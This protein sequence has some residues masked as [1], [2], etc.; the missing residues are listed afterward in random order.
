MGIKISKNKVW[1]GIFLLF[2]GFVLSEAISMP[3]RVDADTAIRGGFFPGILSVMIILLSIILLF[4]KNEP[5]SKE[6][7]NR[8]SLI[9][10]LLIV[11]GIAAYIFLLTKLG[12]LIAGF[13]FV[14]LCARTLG[15]QSWAK[16]ILYSALMVLTIHIVFVVLLNVRFPIG[17]FGI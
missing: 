1:A 7:I 10:G 15:E 17:I 6:S 5:S 14:V 2:G 12:F 8:K 16:V 3:Y 13:L 9:K 11:G 4:M